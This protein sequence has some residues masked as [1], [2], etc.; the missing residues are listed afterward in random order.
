MRERLSWTFKFTGLLIAMALLAAACTSSDGTGTSEGSDVEQTADDADDSNNGEHDAEDTS[1]GDTSPTLTFE[2]PDPDLTRIDLSDDIRMG[3]LDNGLTYFVQ[4]NDS[5]GGS[6]ALRLAVD[7]G[8]LHED[9]LGTGAAHFVEHMMFNGTEKFPGA[10]LDAA[11]RN[12]GAEIGP[13]FN[14]FTSDNATVYQLQV[15]DR[16]ENVDIAFD[17]LA[18]WASAALIEPDAVADEAPVIREELRLRD[19]SSDGLIGVAFETAYFL[20]TPYE[21]TNVSGTAATVNA[22]TAEDLRDF[23]DTWYRPDNMAVIAVGDRSLDDLEDE[24]VQRFEGLTARGDIVPQPEVGAFELRNEPLVEVVVEPGFGDS[25]ISVDYPIRAWDR[26]TIGGN[27]LFL[28]EIVLSIAVN[29]RL[30]EGVDSGRLDLRRAG[31]GWF[32]RNSDLVYMGF[33][34]DADDLVAGTETF[35]TEMQGTLQNPFS[36]EEIARAVE[37]LV[38]SEE[39]RLLEAETTQDSDFADEIVFAFLDGGDL[40]DVDDSVD[41]NLDFLDRFSASDANNHWG[42]MLTSS[43][44]IVLIVGPDAER[45]GDVEGHL[46][47]V[48]A[49]S[50]ATVAAVDD[51]IVEVDVL[52]EA[53]EPVREIESNDLENGDVELVFANGHRVLFADSGISE[54]QIILS[55]ESPGGRA[56]LSDEDGAV[57]ETAVAAVSASGVGPWNPTQL[58]R[59][60]A[61][62]DAGISP[63]VSDFTEGFS[64]SA[65]SEDAE[66]LFQLMHLA[67]TEPRVDD[68]PFSQQIE[69]ARDFVDQVGLDS[70]TAAQVAATN[71]RSGGGNLTGAPT[72]DQ[73]DGLTPAVAERIYTDRFSSLDNHVIVVVG[74]I[75]DDDI[76]DLART[77]VGTLPAAVGTDDP[78]GYPDV[79]NVTERLSVGTGTA[80]GSFLLVASSNAE[81][82]VENLMVSD[83]TSRILDDRIFTVIREELGASYG[84]FSFSRFVEPGDD[85]DLIIS[86]DGDPDRVY[87]IADVIDDELKS[88]AG[89]NISVDD[90]N[91][92]IA[93]IDSELD[94]INNGFITDSLFDEAAGGSGPLLS[95]ASQRQALDSISPADVAAF[96][97]DIITSGQ[98]ID[99]RNI[100]AG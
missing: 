82:T 19:E 16:G 96:V 94:F 62:L 6:V 59:Y 20:G 55:S 83:V 12:I 26:S 36:D 86:V 75:D 61:D 38:S 41:R 24:I 53:P 11:L 91:E 8:G 29:N 57:A 76:T 5:P 9:P 84:G 10:S 45:V 77:W 33:N 98:R 80:G 3:V 87:E 67:I 47:A 51:D 32:P 49:A 4:S 17:V 66:T 1:P 40:D 52:I 22:L 44:P 64:G 90:F 99:I 31:G 39:Q 74:D 89:G 79:G 65:A 54:G 18:Q 23:Y 48:E 68:V 88:V 69:A 81:A 37:V 58:R 7:A 21:G 30:Q 93:V 27:E 72:D 70:A 42:W 34:V 63:V 73:L 13:D 2:A 95:R 35:M 97:D 85:V 14:A 92:A 28:T 43:A 15:A 56:V 100:P 71:A 25:F 46:A 50:Q 78:D 60:L